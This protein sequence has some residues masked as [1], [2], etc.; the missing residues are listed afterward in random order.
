MTV[1]PNKK[2]FRRS[3]RKIFKVIFIHN[4]IKTFLACLQVYFC[5]LEEGPTLQKVEPNYKYTKQQIHQTIN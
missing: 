1:L 3:G 2:M 5:W 4:K